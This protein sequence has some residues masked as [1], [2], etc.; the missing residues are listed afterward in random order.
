MIDNHPR[1]GKQSI[2]NNLV[3]VIDEVVRILDDILII[4]LMI[5]VNKIKDIILKIFNNFKE[6]NFGNYCEDIVVRKDFFLNVYNEVGNDDFIEHYDFFVHNVNRN[7]RENFH[8][9]IEN[10][11]EVSIPKNNIVKENKTFHKRGENGTVDVVIY[12][13]DVFD[14]VDVRI[15]KADIGEVY[16]KGE[17]VN[18]FLNIIEEVIEGSLIK[19][20]KEA[21]NDIDFS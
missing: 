17:N 5:D 3:I 6:D 1:I 21:I 19:E 11:E 2:E 8:T 13:E 4:K 9:N 18:R 16:G 12:D 20:I 14:Q 10:L 15:Y 7:T